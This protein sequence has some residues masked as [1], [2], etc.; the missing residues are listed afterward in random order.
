MAILQNPSRH[1]GFMSYGTDAERNVDPV[2]YQIDAPFGGMDLQLN[3]RV[4]Q[5]EPRQQLPPRLERRWK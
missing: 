5:L 4:L 3:V 2:F 1:H